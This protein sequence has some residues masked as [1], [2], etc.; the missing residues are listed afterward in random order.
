MRLIVQELYTKHRIKPG[1]TYESDNQTIT[2]P[3]TSPTNQ[4]AGLNINLTYIFQV[5]N[6]MNYLIFSKNLIIAIS[7]NR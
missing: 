6:M 4:S 5:K 2:I 7:T 1:E 3:I